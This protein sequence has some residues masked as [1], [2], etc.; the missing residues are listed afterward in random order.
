MKERQTMR[1]I[2]K[3][4]GNCYCLSCDICPF[5]DCCDDSNEGTLIK[6]K[7]WLKDNPSKEPPLWVYGIILLVIAM[8]TA[9]FCNGGF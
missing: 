9:Y 2:I 5:I 1:K 4:K 8:I 3:Q 6:A 7:Q